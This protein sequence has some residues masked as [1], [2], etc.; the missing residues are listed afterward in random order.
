MFVRDAD[1]LFCAWTEQKVWYGS[2]LFSCPS[3]MES[4][5]FL[6][7]QV[8]LCGLAIIFLFAPWFLIDNFFLLDANGDN[9]TTTTTTLPVL[10]FAF[11]LVGC[12]QVAMFGF[13]R[14]IVTST[15]RN[16]MPLAGRVMALLH[17]SLV[18]AFGKLYIT[19]PY[20]IHKPFWFFPF[21]HGSAC[22][23]HVGNMYWRESSS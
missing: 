13:L 21:Y 22:L 8:A 2:T 16:N 4:S 23:V 10:C 7:E 19:A 11:N 14:I 9:Q 5:L 6:F 15:S 17:F 12:C 3:S 1:A 18:A 20:V